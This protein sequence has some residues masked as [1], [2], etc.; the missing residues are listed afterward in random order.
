VEY[1]QYR[2]ERVRGKATVFASDAL[3]LIHEATAGQLRN[4]DRIATAC[5][6]TDA[7]SSTS[8][9]NDS[10][11][12]STTVDALRKIVETAYRGFFD[13]AAFR[14]AAPAGAPARL[15]CYDK[16]AT[17]TPGEHPSPTHWSAVAGAACSAA[18]AT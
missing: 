2:V 3:A 17:T 10:R 7:S 4:V 16:I 1:I 13:R 9:A 5:L 18:G 8:I 15:T 11:T 6:R 12:W 14:I